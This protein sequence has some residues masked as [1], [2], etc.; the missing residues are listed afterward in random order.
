[1]S[2]IF[3]FTE[4]LLTRELKPERQKDLLEKIHRQSDAMITIINEL[5]DLARMEARGS[6][7]IKAEPVDLLEVVERVVRDY[8]RPGER[9]RPLMS[10]PARPVGDGR[11][12]KGTAGRAQC[13]VQRLQI[14]PQGG[15]VR[16]EF[17]Q[18]HASATGPRC[19]VRIT[20]QGIGLTPEQLARMGERFFR[21]DQSGNIPG[22][23]LGVSI[24]QEIMALMEGEMLIHSE[25]GRGTEVTL[26]LP[27]S[28]SDPGS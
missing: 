18:D 12:A 16:I 17:L 4:L 1:M 11:S 5:L 25:W 21:A 3:G 2:S 27:A 14:L 10:S 7:E 28:R 6:K 26:W 20:D 19:G 22:T 23:G 9:P 13:A 24:V 15:D 8:Q